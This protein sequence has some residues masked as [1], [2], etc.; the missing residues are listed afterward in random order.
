M[1]I[2]VQGL[3]ASLAAVAV[4]MVILW[5]ASLLLHNASIVDIFWGPGF[6]VACVAALAG[7]GRGSPR[8]VLALSLVI[9]WAARLAVHI[10]LRNRGQEEDLRYRAMRRRAG[11]GFAWRSLVEVFLLQALLLWLVSHPLLVVMTAREATRFGGLDVVAL[12][13]WLIGFAFETI[14]DLQLTRFRAD[15]SNRGRVLRTGLW[16]WTRH[17]NYFGEALIWWGFYLLTA[18]VPAGW[19][20]MYAPVLMTF[21]LVRVSGVALL[22]RTLAESKPEYSEYMNEVSPFLPLPPRRRVDSP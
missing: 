19:V 11:Q 22:E 3:A 20:T 17:P 5:V 16:R 2:L 12:A 18:S 21:L 6:V 9:V 4:M 15:A 8:A 13:V 7:A 1:P 10:Y 14:G